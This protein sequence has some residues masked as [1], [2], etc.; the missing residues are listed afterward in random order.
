[1]LRT[2]AGRLVT[3]RGGFVLAGLFDLL[4]FAIAAARA[5]HRRRSRY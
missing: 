1:M 2:V 3:G 5:A 4:A